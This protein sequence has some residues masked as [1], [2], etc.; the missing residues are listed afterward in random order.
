MIYV[1]ETLPEWQ[2]IAL[3]VLTDAFIPGEKQF[4]KDLDKRVAAALPPELKRMMKKIM[5]FVGMV[6]DDAKV[7]G[8]EAL[9]RSAKFTER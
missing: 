5:P 6:R 8:A 4:P 9:D 2:R 3:E 7:R 1:C